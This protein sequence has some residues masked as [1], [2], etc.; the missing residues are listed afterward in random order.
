MEVSDVTAGGYLLRMHLEDA[1]Q[2]GMSW[3]NNGSETLRGGAAGAGQ[4]PVWGRSVTRVHQVESAFVALDDMVD[5]AGAET[6]A[7]MTGAR[8]RQPK[9]A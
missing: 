5:S 9:R 7:L 8:R 2:T 6:V 3:R 4:I 1:K